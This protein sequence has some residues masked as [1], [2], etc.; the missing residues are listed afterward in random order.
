M[1]LVDTPTTKLTEAQTTQWLE[2]IKRSKRADQKYF[3]RMGVWKN[4]VKGNYLKVKQITSHNL[5]VNLAYAHYRSKLPVLFY[6]E[7][8]V[9]C[10]TDDPQRSEDAE[11]WSTYINKILRRNGYKKDTK[12]TVGD[13]ILCGEGWKKIVVFKGVDEGDGPM[14][15]AS[16]PHQASGKTTVASVWVPPSDVIVDYQAPGRDPDSGTCRFV[17]IRYLKN[18]D[19]L[20]ADPRYNVPSQDELDAA[21]FTYSSQASHQGFS[22]K[23]MNISDRILMEADTDTYQGVE[24]MTYIYEVWVNQL[25]HDATGMKMRRQ[26]FVLMEGC[27]RPI[28]DPLPWDQFYGPEFPG[29]PI[30]RVALNT[31]P[32]DYPIAEIE[33]WYNLNQ[34]INYVMNR[35]LDQITSG[36][37]V[38]LLDKSK[39][40]DPHKTIRAMN[41]GLP[42]TTVSVKAGQL[43]EAFNRLPG[44]PVQQD[45]FQILNPLIQLTERVSGSSRNRQQ[46]VGIR[47]AAEVQNV[48]QFSQVVENEQIDTI[49]DF[50]RVDV[51]KLVAVLKNNTTRE[52]VRSLLGYLGN[53]EWEGFSDENIRWQ[54][55]IDIEVDSFRQRNQREK[56]QAWSVILQSALQVFPVMPNLRIDHI[57]YKWLEAQDIDPIPVM[58]DMLDQRIYQMIE[59]VGMMSGQPAEVSP[60]DHHQSH[61]ETIRSFKNTDAYQ[62]MPEEARQLVDQHEMEHMEANEI[63]QESSARMQNVS[64]AAGQSPF[65]ALDPAK[66]INTTGGNDASL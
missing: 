14:S 41:R 56:V 8:T 40:E 20:R 50:L 57:F 6:R 47:T 16:E 42:R 53:V 4:G 5:T 27:K 51:E 9:V 35:T 23:R 13:S 48:E 60:E 30:H 45:L 39:L 28:R 38:N 19:E 55:D 10:R 43:G 31:M 25:I 61:L 62:M 29:W 46:A 66:G 33:S 63:I 52:D 65:D 1:K 3:E 24:D 21:Q 17:A 22:K 26:M 15:E 44:S 37:P 36:G 59:I 18:I 12:S 54:P 58:G 2:L 34:A 49:H 7:P 64:Q 11:V 32:G